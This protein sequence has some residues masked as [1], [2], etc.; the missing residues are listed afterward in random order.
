M[1]AGSVLI[2]LSLAPSSP[3]LDLPEYLD[4]SPIPL[5]PKHVYMYSIALIPFGCHNIYKPSVES[6]KP[7]ISEVH[8]F[9]PVS[10]TEI[11]LLRLLR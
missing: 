8:V 4:R 7:L 3:V 5:R 11:F 2:L 1:L 6:W 10:I 9:G